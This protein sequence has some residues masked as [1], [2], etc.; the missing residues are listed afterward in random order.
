MDERTDRQTDR[1][2]CMTRVQN[3]GQLGTE[4]ERGAH[5]R[6]RYVGYQTGIKLAELKMEIK[7]MHVYIRTYM[8]TLY[9]EHHYQLCVSLVSRVFECD[10]AEPQVSHARNHNDYNSKVCTYERTYNV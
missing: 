9:V 8:C 10:G 4:R 6:T 7:S 5:S 2:T 3:E 1:Q